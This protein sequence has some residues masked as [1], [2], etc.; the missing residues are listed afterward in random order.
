M[1]LQK[2][3]SRKVLAVYPSFVRRYGTPCKLA[4]APLRDVRNEIRLLGISDRARRLKASARTILENY[5]GQ[6]PSNRKDLLRLLGVGDYIANAVLC[7]A[8]ARDVAL[9]DTNVIRVLGRVFS[10]RSS[11]PRAR[12]DGK[13]WGFAA[14]LVPEGKAIRYNRAVL[15][16]AALVCTARDPRCRECPVNS[17][18]NYYDAAGS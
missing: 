2:T 1:M 7:F 10:V 5:H 14:R 11:K 4:Y 8:Y 6:V 12:T 17:L 16:F 15:D 9:L 13:L 18:C 3:D